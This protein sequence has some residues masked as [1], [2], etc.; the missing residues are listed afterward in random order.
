MP[1]EQRIVFTIRKDIN[2]QMK[3]DMG[4]F[5]KLARNEGA[6]NELPMYQ[7]EMQ[8]A[9]ARIG[10]YVMKALADGEHKEPSLPSEKTAV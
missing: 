3:I 5:P 7:R 2:G 10:G 4:F 9:A 1:K 6:F 8:N